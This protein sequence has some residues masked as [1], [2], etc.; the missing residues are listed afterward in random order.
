MIGD[1]A[2]WC[3]G[4]ASD[5]REDDISSLVSTGQSVNI[6]YGL[7]SSFGQFVLQAVNSLAMAQ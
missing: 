4:Q 3:P 1:R 5:I 2:G 7:I 6:D